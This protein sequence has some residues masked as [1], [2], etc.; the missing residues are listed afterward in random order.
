M[1][2]KPEGSRL[3]L[4]SSEKDASGKALFQCRC[5]TTK[6]IR[7]S[8]VK[9]GAVVSCGCYRKARNFSHGKTET[10]E[11]AAW[12]NMI[13]RCYNKNH[14][15]YKN[16]GYRGI[17]VC[18]EWKTNFP[19][20]LSHIGERPSGSKEFKHSID[21]IDNSRGY[22]PGNVRWADNKTQGRNRRNNKFLT[23]RGA[24][25]TWSEWAAEIGI[26]LSTFRRRMERG[27][28]LERVVLTSRITSAEKK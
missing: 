14:P 6:R 7:L 18:D 28:S 3:T 21:R 16:Y 23:F 13:R 5:G 9:C 17:T 25:R 26:A 24:T 11:Y 8:H 19:A 27:W 1:P 12:K 22:E 2:D 15:E 20:F 4:V 10:V